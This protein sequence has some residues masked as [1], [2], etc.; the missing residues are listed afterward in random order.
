MAMGA[1]VAAAAYLLGSVDFA[2]VIARARGVDIYSEGS[3]NP[4][5][6]NVFRSIGKAAGVASQRK[7]LTVPSD[8]SLAS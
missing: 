6:S 8:G 4:G 3:G 7:L 5:A 1:L 2:V